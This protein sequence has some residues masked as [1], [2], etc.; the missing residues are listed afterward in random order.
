MPKKRNLFPCSH[1]KTPS[2]SYI[3]PGRNTPECSTCRKAAVTRFKAKVEAEESSEPATTDVTK[4]SAKPSLHDDETM[5]RLIAK[6]PSELEKLLKSKSERVRLSVLQEIARRNEQAE[7]LDYVVPARLQAELD[8]RQR[9]MDALVTDALHLGMTT[10]FL[11][12]S[13]QLKF[14]DGLVCKFYRDGIEVHSRGAVAVEV[15]ASEEPELKLIEEAPK[16]VIEDAI[17]VGPPPCCCG[18]A[19]DCHEQDSAGVG[20]TCSGTRGQGCRKGCQLYT[21]VDSDDALKH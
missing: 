10:F 1:P 12:E 3:R 2:N 7:K 21:A 14:A 8:A 19:F 11:W 18:C 4:P 20:G 6:S 16:Q 13:G 9:R 5:A 17:V 15:I